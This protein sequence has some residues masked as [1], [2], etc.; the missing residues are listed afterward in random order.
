[1]S[2][3]LTVRYIAYGLYFVSLVYA[4][5]VVLPIFI[6]NKPIKSSSGSKS[7]GGFSE[8]M[9]V[10]SDWAQKSDVYEANQ[11]HSRRVADI[12]RQIGEKYGLT[13]EELD[14]IECASLLHD[15][16]QIENFDFINELRE[17]EFAERIGLEGHTLIGED[18]VK[19]IANVGNAGLWVRWHHERWDGLG[20]PDQLSGEMIPLPVRIISVADAYDALTH[21][22]PHRVALSTED[23]L[24][25]LQKMSGIMFDPNVIQVFMSIDS[26][27]DASRSLEV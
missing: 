6:G 17:L 5:L 16:G 18:F 26:D 19:Q 2:T 7:G 27:V 21:D 8:L 10:I 13:K 1:M 24:R 14:V 20:Y 9:G 25:E 3:A 15:V 4:I 22:R 12:A 11:G 23:A